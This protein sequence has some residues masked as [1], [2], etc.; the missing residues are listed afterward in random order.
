[1]ALNTNFD[2]IAWLSE[3]ELKVKGSTEV[4]PAEWTPVSRNFVVTQKDCKVQ[5]TAETQ[6]L[7][8]KATKKIPAAGFAPGAAVAAGTETHYRKGPSGAPASFITITWSQTITIKKQ[9][10]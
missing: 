10:Q 8:W 5:R 2:E 9:P 4:V 7:N 1:M 6:G 3:T